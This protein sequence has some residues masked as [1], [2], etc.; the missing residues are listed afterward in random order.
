MS[1]TARPARRRRGRLLASGSV[2]LA[3]VLATGFVAPAPSGA[4]TTDVEPVEVQPISVQ[5]NRYAPFATAEEF[6]E[7]QYL[8]ILRRQ[9]KAEEVDYQVGLLEGGREPADLIVEFVESAEAN[10]NIRAVVRL[11][12][13]YFLRNP[14]FIGLNHWISRRQAGIKLGNV[15]N[16]FATSPEFA[17]RYGT[18]NDEGFVDMVYK[19]VMGRPA[20]AKGKAYWLEKLAVGLYRGQLMTSFSDSPEYTA[21]S[22][23]QTTAITLYNGMWQKSIPRGIADYMGPALQSGRRELI[24]FAREYLA[25]PRYATRF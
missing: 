18:L 24:E 4:E 8:D 16:D 11:Y 14:D 7:Q 19:N 23:G 9:P 6:V 17:I 3:L 20:D 13:T 2:A 25:D 1:F 5:V 15:S 10:S 22:W 12:R 21:G